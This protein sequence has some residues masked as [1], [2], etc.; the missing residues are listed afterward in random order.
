VE[1]GSE[2]GRDAEPHLTGNGVKHTLLS[3]KGILQLLWIA[4]KEPL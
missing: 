1:T 3:I 4:V 2:G